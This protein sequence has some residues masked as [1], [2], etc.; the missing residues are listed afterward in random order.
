MMQ[1]MEKCNRRNGSIGA[2]DLH[3]WS[4]TVA[5]FLSE[6]M[7][8]S[9]KELARVSLGLLCHMHVSNL[10]SMHSFRMDGGRRIS[11]H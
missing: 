5:G 9:A 11:S 6:T 1:L 7:S 3:R 2:G 4:P 10:Y 8:A